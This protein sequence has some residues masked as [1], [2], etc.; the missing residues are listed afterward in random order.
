M[1]DTSKS[2]ARAHGHVLVGDAG[3]LDGHVPA[4]E[5]DHARAQGAMPRVQRC[6]FQS[7]G[8]WLCH[9]EKAGP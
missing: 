1:W 6:L 3:V 4:A 9:V 5:L 2:R 7:D 8:R